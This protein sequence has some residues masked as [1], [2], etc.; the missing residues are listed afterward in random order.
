MITSISKSNLE[1]I[2][3]MLDEILKR[4]DNKSVLNRMSTRFQN[5]YEKVFLKVVLEWFESFQKQISDDLYRKFI[6]ASGVDIT[7][8]LTDWK[9]IEKEGVSTLKPA[10][11]SI[12]GK[13]GDASFRVAGIEGS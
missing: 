7:T 8:K 1:R 10:F 9:F 12:M 6:K 2:D 4:I 11:L 3:E 5:I 13:A